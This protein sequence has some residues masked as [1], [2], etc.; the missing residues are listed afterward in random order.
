MRLR[1]KLALAGAPLGLC[2]GLAAV[3]GLWT[4]SVDWLI[5]LALALASAVFA[6]RR[7]P[8]A[9]F[10]N[11]VLLGFAVLF[12]SRL[13]L[14][15]QF[16]TYAGNNPEVATAYRN[17]PADFPLAPRTLSFVSGFLVAGF[18]AALTGGLASIAARLTSK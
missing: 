18:G 11:A 14:S 6:A 4:R 17:L 16:D 10:R 7:A 5:L 2:A 3:H 13:V 9:A 1:W 8:D 12:C 15:I